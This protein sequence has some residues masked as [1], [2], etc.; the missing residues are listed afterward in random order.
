MISFRKAI[1]FCS[2]VLTLAIPF[3]ASAA[4]FDVKTLIDVDNSRG[5]GCNVVT[6][7]GIVSGIDVMITTV[8]T[9]NGPTGT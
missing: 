3:A 7:G 1:R 4:T 8:G 5:T 9:V 2:L 6:P